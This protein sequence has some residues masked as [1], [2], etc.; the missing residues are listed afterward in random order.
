MKNLFKILFLSC[1]LFMAGCTSDFEEINT[2]P[3]AFASAPY[4][5]MFGYVLRESVFSVI[6]Y[7]TVKFSLAVA[8]YYVPC[9]K[10]VSLIHPH[11]Q[12]CVR[13]IRKSP[14]RR[15]QLIRGYTKIKYDPINACD[16]VPHEFFP[17]AAIVTPY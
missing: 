6:P 1:G 16:V 7:N 8:V 9:R 17:D 10:V 2:D 12:R 13:H 5:N 11:I 15:I 14:L 4:T 3:D